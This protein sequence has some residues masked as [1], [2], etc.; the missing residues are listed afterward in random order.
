VPI[1]VWAIRTERD[2]EQ[3]RDVVD[4][5]IMK[6]R[7]SK[8]DE[9]RLEILVTLMEVY[10]KKKY[11]ADFPEVTPLELLKMLMEEREMSASDLGRLLGNRSLGSL[12][13]T[14]K[15]QLSKA[16]IRK[17]SEHFKIDPSALF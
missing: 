10:E 12:I 17:L 4:S 1:R 9:E 2:Y 15:R 5:L 11:R 7:L 14:G 8:K 3:A 6:T 13:L 16:H